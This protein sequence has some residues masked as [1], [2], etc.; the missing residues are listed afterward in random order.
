MLD[1]AVLYNIICVIISGLLS[2]RRQC[3]LQILRP[4]GDETATHSTTGKYIFSQ[5][6]S[7]TDQLFI[8]ASPSHP[9]LSMRAPIQRTSCLVSSMLALTVGARAYTASLYIKSASSHDQLR[10]SKAMPIKNIP[11]LERILVL[12]HSSS[13]CATPEI[14]H[15]TIPK[16]R[17]IELAD[18]LS[19]SA[20]PRASS[21]STVFDSLVSFVSL[22]YLHFLC[23]FR[24]PSFL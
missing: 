11:E 21:L 15:F 20:Q 17:H 19:Y 10:P 14:G 23:L 18:T 4:S 2:V 1:R 8:N 6:Q 12:L 5:V 13:L 16:L 22:F 9:V 7:H 3:L 24:L